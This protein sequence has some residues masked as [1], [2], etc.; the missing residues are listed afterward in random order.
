MP[1]TVSSKVSP[2]RSYT[3]RITSPLHKFQRTSSQIPNEN[4]NSEQILKHLF[5]TLCWMLKTTNHQTCVFSHLLKCWLTQAAPLNLLLSFI[6]CDAS[7][8]SISYR[9]S[10]RTSTLPIRVSP[11]TSFNCPT[12]TCIL[13]TIKRCWNVASD[14]WW[15]WLRLR[16][17]PRSPSFKSRHASC[18]F[19][20]LHGLSSLILAPKH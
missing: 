5:L 15:A 4:T 1:N 19:H 2:T 20:V 13:W 18:L 7:I 3:N 17:K 12:K 14:K 9:C 6:D 16:F 10:S 8:L 11:T